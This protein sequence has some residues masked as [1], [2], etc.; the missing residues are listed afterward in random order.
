VLQKIASQT[1]INSVHAYCPE[2]NLFCSPIIAGGFIRSFFAGEPIND[3]D[4]Y[5]HNK[6]DLEKSYSKLIAHRWLTSF[7]S[8]RAITLKQGGKTVQLISFYYG[9]PE[10]IIKRFDFTI[11]SAAFAFK[12]DPD[13]EKPVGI[14]YLHDNFFEHLAGRLLIYQSS[15]LPLSTLKRVIKFVK[16]GYH[17]CDENLIKIIESIAHDVNFENSE[18]L[19]RHIAGLDPE[20]ER[21]I[22]VID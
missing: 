21:R 20:G 2:F 18:E 17:I 6:E 8:E 4:V 14:F 19:E 1:F 22:R 5:F 7:K 15:E 12:K 9:E 11:S 13:Q 3:M 10:E 16:R